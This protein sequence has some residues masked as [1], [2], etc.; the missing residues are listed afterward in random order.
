MA[1]AKPLT[2]IK[3]IPNDDFKDIKDDTN[4]KLEVCEDA[5]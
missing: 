3:E 4:F 1:T 2:E 5:D